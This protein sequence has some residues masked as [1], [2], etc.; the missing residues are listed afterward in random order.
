MKNFI[1]ISTLILVSAQSSALANT[2]MNCHGQSSEGSLEYVWN[3]STPSAGFATADYQS[4]IL[5]ISK[6]ISSQRLENFQYVSES[7]VI[8]TDEVKL[9]QLPG[10]NP[11]F[12]FYESIAPVYVDLDGKPESSRSSDHAPAKI[13]G[14]YH[15]FKAE[16]ETKA[17]AA[18]KAKVECAI[19]VTEAS[20]MDDLLRALRLDKEV[21]AK[22]IE[23]QK[24][25]E[26]EFKKKYGY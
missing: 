6:R 17:L 22:V 19:S 12:S 9:T 26:A 23:A 16:V 4:P 24:Q 3:N 10:E 21:A 7:K 20:D 11:S 5:T 25:R 18:G 15:S 8:E 1:M 13:Y 2:K 14:G